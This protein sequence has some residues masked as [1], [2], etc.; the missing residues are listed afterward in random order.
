MNDIEKA[1]LVGVYLPFKSEA[2]TDYSLEELRRLAETAH[3][4]VQLVF[5]QKRES[6]HSAWYIGKG[7]IEELLRLVDELKTDLV[8]FN[9]ELSPSQIRNIEKVLSCK[10]IDRTQLILDIFAGRAKS[11]DGK[12]QV[13]LAQL[14]Y[15]LPRLSGKG[16]SLSRLGGGIG[17]RGP[18]ETKLETD[19]RH[20]R[21]RIHEIKK[22]LEG[23]ERHREL[24]RNRRKKNDTFQVAIVGY[25]NAGKSTLLNQLSGSEILA[26]DR[27]FATLDPTSRKV[28]LPTGKE[29]ILTDTVGFI[30]DLPHDLVAAFRS[31]LEE[32]R[33]SNLILH[34][35]DASHPYYFEQMKVVEKLLK[36]INAH[37][38]PSITVYN[39]ADLLHTTSD[40]K[41]QE[42]A[43][44]KDQIYLSAFK[45]DDLGRLLSLIEEK[46]SENWMSYT[47]IIPAERA[48]LLSYLHNHGKLL[49]K[50]KWDEEEES[51]EVS[52]ELNKVYLNNELKEFLK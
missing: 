9:A 18:G 33:E 6:I 36:E 31:T 49:D 38:I 42:F 26:E 20:I 51:W 2:K 27:L 34:V 32:S 8:I 45:E 7:K 11:K 1:I 15:L 30:Q 48:D 37:T 29:I 14:N 24:Y 10:V 46:L 4:E 35:V 39:K 52:V 50:A 13:E 44:D 19:R 43:N 16:L 12:N 40:M 28:M 22:N 3:A 25:T 23:M 5:T 47:F 21:H 41:R 17:T